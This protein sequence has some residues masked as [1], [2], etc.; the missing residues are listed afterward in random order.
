MKILGLHLK[1]IGP[2]TDFE[3]DLSGGNRGL[4]LIYG[5]NEAGKSSTLRA[6]NY[7]LFGFPKQLDDDF[8]HPYRSLR[9]GAR[10]VNDAGDELVC[11]RRKA[12][13]NNLRAADDQEVLPEDALRKFLGPLDRN[14][15][16]TFF[17]ID[18]PALVRGGRAMLEG[19]GDV[20]EL[21]FSGSGLAH[22][23]AIGK[24]LEEQ[25]GALFVPNPLGKRQLNNL[26][27]ELEQAEAAVKE[28]QLLP[29]EWQ[30]HQR[31]LEQALERKA[32]FDEAMGEVGREKSRLERLQK[33]I[34]LANRRQHQQALLAEL[35][36]AVRLPADFRERRHSLEQQLRLSE[37]E[38]DRAAEEIARLTKRLEGLAVPEALLAQRSRVKAIHAKLDNYRNACEDLPQLEARRSEIETRVAATLRQLGRDLERADAAALEVPLAEQKR[39]RDL[40]AAY[41]SLHN[42]AETARRAVA[43]LDEK[44]GSLR[45]ELNRLP[46]QKNTQ[47]LAEALAAAR[48]LGDVESQCDEITVELRELERELDAKR[49]RLPQWSGRLEALARLP[50]PATETIERFEREFADSDDVLRSLEEKL[51]ACQAERLEID[52]ELERLRLEQAV[53]SE[54]DLLSRRENRDQLWQQ[55]QAQAAAGPVADD[56]LA[57]FEQSLRDADEIADRLRRE[58]DRVTT[59]ARLT[60]Q[61][62]ANIEAVTALEQQRH[63]QTKSREDLLARWQEAWQACSLEPLSPREMLAWQR[64]HR[65]LAGDIERL[66]TLRERHEELRHRIQHHRQALRQPLAEFSAEH[67]A[68]DLSLHRWMALAEESLAE[69]EADNRQR[70]LLQR[71]L[72]QVALERARQETRLQQAGQALDD[73]RSDWKTAIQAL[74]LPPD[75]DPAAAQAV[76]DVIRELSALLKESESLR[77]RIEEQVQPYRAEFEREVRELVD[78]LVVDLAELPILQAA[79]AL[80][81]QLIEAISAAENRQRLQ[82]QREAA[83]G[84]HAQATADLNTHQEELAAM[85]R[86]ARCASA[87]ELAAA[88][89]RSQRRCAIEEEIARLEE[90]LLELTAGGSLSDFLAEVEQ[91]DADQLGVRMQRCRQRME[92]LSQEASD[93]SEQ[94]GAEK[95]ILEQMDSSGQ[96]V[97]AAE[98]VSDLRA[99]VTATA[100][101][102]A[103]LALART[104]LR[105]GIERYRERHQEAMIRRAS[106]LFAQLT[107]GSFAE[108]RVDYT[109]EGRAEL[110]GIRGEKSEV[111]PVSGMSDGTADQLYLALRLA[112]LETYLDEHERIPLVVDD[113]LIQ[114]DDERAMATL[115]ILSELSSRT[116]V[117]FFT[118]HRHLVDLAGEAV[119]DATLFVHELPQAQRAGA[120]A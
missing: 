2:F 94:V 1:A 12:I 52:R 63:E 36:D 81:D 64:Q 61:R 95:K 47:P 82:E 23:H 11:I 42:E 22:L 77:L 8:L 73:W 60:A 5:P 14:M 101:E 71:D 105:R 85:C 90:R 115:R 72:E 45:D 49:A 21:L 40:G 84:E 111:V 118:H 66:Q 18:H 55:I 80:N 20:G 43:E 110:V 32:E 96:S 29:A 97:E 25:A 113:V 13:K 106:E 87:D 108:L 75:A 98:R 62:R 56:W 89:E 112:W 91:A 28:Y 119:R 116:Q 102:Y 31:A 15:F 41:Q 3:L 69:A 100:E 30:Q 50:V 57:E 74:P 107:V 92:E 19:E 83:R 59:Q 78:E 44:F 38:R 33:G 67:A 34:P 46:K 120:L 37:R 4:H 51:A 6:L 114:F 17:G 48:R 76:L 26:L 70:E 35:A 54:T 9:V 65:E 99:R 58:A 79:I 93:V 109:A 103:R 53:P 68:E 27:R 117:L 39:I 24:Q 7:L 88:E 104:V 16:T 86:E 10:L